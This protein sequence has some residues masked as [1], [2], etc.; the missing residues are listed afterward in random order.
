M[1][2]S[3]IIFVKKPVFTEL[4]R[5]GKISSLFLTVKGEKG[6]L[7]EEDCSTQHSPHPSSMEGRRTQVHRGPPSPQQ[8]PVTDKEGTGVWESHEKQMTYF[9]YEGSK[10]DL[11]HFGGPR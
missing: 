6:R 10:G 3:L 4:N 8:E 2:K 9:P 5:T 11:V 1:K 7:L